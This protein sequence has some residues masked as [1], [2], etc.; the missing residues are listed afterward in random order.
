MDASRS[1]SAAPPAR[2]GFRFF[3]RLAFSLALI[4]ALLW[5]IPYSQ[6]LASLAQVS[7][8]GLALAVIP[9]VV[10]Q[11]IAVTRW[12]RMLSR[13]GAL[14]SY[15]E[16]LLDSLVGWA[17]NLVLPST[18]GG[19]FV[20]ALRCG[21]RLPIPH[22]AW[23]TVI[24]ERIIGLIVL[25][26]LAIPGMVLMR[27]GHSLIVPALLLCALA[28]AFLLFAR[29][30]LLWLAGLVVRRAPVLAG[31][32]QGIAEDL[33]GP[34]AR[35]RPRAECF[36]LSLAYQLVSISILAACVL[37]SGDGELLSAIYAA[38]PLIAIGVMLPVTIAGIGVRE[39]LF[40]IVLGRL[41]VKS[42]M[43]FALAALWMGWGIVLAL[44]GVA[45]LLA[46]TSRRSRQP[47]QPH[48]G[49]VSV[50]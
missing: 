25:T 45:V 9:L 7:G 50:E 12:R 14:A 26:L 15:R 27:G 49:S 2:R 35:F 13:T 33:G 23:S 6:V 1:A 30:P 34:L 47:A 11:H 46:E 4:A 16:L 17:Y 40:V 38:L 41:G 24:Y 48:Q 5:K 21:Q 3:F 31:V 29:R 36:A 28:G 42:P 18:V 43:A 32:S 39:S 10:Q 8:I 22:H 44:A 37:P 20:R 19:D